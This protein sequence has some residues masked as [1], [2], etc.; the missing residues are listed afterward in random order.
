MVMSPVDVGLVFETARELEFEP[1]GAPP[2][3]VADCWRIVVE[4]PEGIELAA[5]GV[6]EPG[7]AVVKL[8]LGSISEETQGHKKRAPKKK[9]KRRAGA[10]REEGQGS[11]KKFSLQLQTSR[12]AYNLLIPR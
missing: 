10:Q 3:G 12:E 11:R 5:V 9:G 8:T 1:L 2:L 7:G 4:G 6:V